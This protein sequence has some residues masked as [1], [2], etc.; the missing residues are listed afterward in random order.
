MNFRRAFTLTELLVVIGIVAV[1]IALI[2]PAVQKVR[3][4]ANKMVCA[5]NLRQ[6]GLA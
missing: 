3:E 2:L 4:T 5:N 6:L 1:L